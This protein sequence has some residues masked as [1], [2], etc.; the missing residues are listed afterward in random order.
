[1]PSNSLRFRIFL[2]LSAFLP[3][4]HSSIRCSNS[5]LEI[6]FMILFYEGTSTALMFLLKVSYL[7]LLYRT[8][9]KWVILYLYRFPRNRLQSTVPTLLFPSYPYS[10]ITPAIRAF[11]ITRTSTCLADSSLTGYCLSH[12]RHLCVL[13]HL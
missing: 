1:M 8:L 6:S 9:I 13:R 5:D 10:S 4:I 7:L 12:S 11:L 2:S 3:M